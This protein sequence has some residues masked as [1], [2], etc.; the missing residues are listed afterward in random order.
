MAVPH[1]PAANEY[2]EEDADAALVAKQQAPL[3]EM[4]TSGFTSSNVHSGIYDFGERELYMRYLRATG[5][6][7]IYRYD[8]VPAQEWQGLKSAGSKGSYINANVAFE[9]AYVRMNRGNMP[10]EDRSA[11]ADQRVRRFVQTP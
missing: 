5:A 9:Y 10:T 11:I 7:A 3:E 4:P 2:F 1:H 8:N 6:D